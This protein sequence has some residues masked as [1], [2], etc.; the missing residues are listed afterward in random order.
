MGERIHTELARDY[1]QVCRERDEAR[2]EI[3]RLRSRYSPDLP[4]GWRQEYGSFPLFLT[5]GDVTV[6]VD[7]EELTVEWSE[8]RDD[9]F[10]QTTRRALVPL[11]VVRALLAR[12]EVAGG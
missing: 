8:S 3:A 11:S 1:E 5:D 7:D 10:G 12:L 6:D 4:D 9:H 2:A